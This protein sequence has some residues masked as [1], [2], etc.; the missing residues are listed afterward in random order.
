MT[1]LKIFCYYITDRSVL[2]LT[3]GDLMKKQNKKIIILETAKKLFA[4]KGYDATGMEEI[5]LTAA[6]PK[7]LIYYHYNCKM[8]LLNAIIA[9]FLNN[10]Q[11]I[12]ENGS[13]RG[14]D[15][16]SVYLDFVQKNRDC[17]KILLSE[18]LKKSTCALEIFNSVKTLEKSDKDS[19]K[20]ESL[21]LVAEF[22]TSIIPTLFFACY[23]ENW[24]KY[25]ET[26]TESVEADFLEAYKLTHG[27]YH[28]H[29][30]KE[31]L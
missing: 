11:Q 7:S 17:A 5:A 25:F 13:Q 10:Y 28:E 19:K 6:V 26:D 15:K 21:Q 20:A 29:I 30:K 18:S 31:S 12:L 23:Q 24:C 22:F 4:D 16:I 27:A 2:I 9:Q 1:K 14:I 3:K 8:D